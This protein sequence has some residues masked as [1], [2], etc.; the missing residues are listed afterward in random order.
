MAYNLIRLSR[1]N[2]T[3]IYKID[4]LPITCFQ[5]GMAID[6]DGSPRAYHPD[7]TG[8]DDLKHGGYPG[9]WWGIATSDELASGEPLIQKPQDPAPGFYVSTTSLIDARFKYQNPLRYV[10]AEKIPYFVLPDHFA[11]TISLGDIAWIYN[12]HQRSGCFA[13]F[14]DVGPDVGEGSMY[15]AKQ[16]GIDNHPRFGG[17]A[18]GILYFIFD[19]SGKGNGQHLTKK[20]INQAGNKILKSLHIPDLVALFKLNHTG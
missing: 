5:A 20:E 4:G 11:E 12:T 9:N 1:F 10:N 8:L 2:K 3:V 13:V 7:N 14:A 15:L 17:I 6:A 18:T 19:C 16:L